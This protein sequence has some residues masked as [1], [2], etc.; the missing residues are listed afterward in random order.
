MAATARSPT[1]LEQ[2]LGRDRIGVVVGEELEDPARA[3]HGVD[4]APLEHHADAPRERPVLGGGIEPQDAHGSGR[5]PAV[6]LEGFDRGGLARPVRTQHDEDLPGLGHQVDPVDGG[7]GCGAVAH[8]EAADLDCGHG[9]A[10]YFLS[11]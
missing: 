5:W 2:V 8:R 11:K 3:E 6:A 4:A 10:D 9:A 1:Q 7:G